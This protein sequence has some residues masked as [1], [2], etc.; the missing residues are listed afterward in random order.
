MLAALAFASPARAAESK[1]VVECVDAAVK[2]ANSAGDYSGYG[3]ATNSFCVLG[4]WLS[5]GESFKYKM[6]VQKGKG[7][8]F[9]GAGDRDVADLDIS[10]TDGTE[11]VSDTE[12]DNTPWVHVGA[13]SNVDA[14]ITVTNFKGSGEADFCCLVILEEGG[15]DGSGKALMSAVRGLAAQLDKI[16]GVGTEKTG[17]AICF[18]GGLFG[19]GGKLGIERPFAPGEYGLVGYGDKN[20]VDLDLGLYEGGE[21]VAE[22]TG[23]D[24]TPVVECEV[25]ANARGVVQLRMHEAKGNAWGLCVVLVEEE[26]EGEGEGD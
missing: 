25:S 18:M 16:D 8:L 13:D 23:K 11:T 15:A 4:G 22:D 14:T 17:G 19:T 20:C 1:Y 10:V 24:A 26:H 21:L 6:P 2:Q 12:H 3:A 5:T 9:V 7:Y